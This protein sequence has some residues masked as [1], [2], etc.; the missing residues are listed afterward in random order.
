MSREHSSES[1]A[2]GEHGYS[3]AEQRAEKVKPFAEPSLLEVW[4]RDWWN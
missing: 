4:P 3:R 1:W 2:D